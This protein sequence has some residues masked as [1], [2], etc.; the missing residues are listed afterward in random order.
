MALT[1]QST[2]VG[3][4]R[5]VITL[6]DLFVAPECRRQGIATALLAKV[7][8]LASPGA[9]LTLTYYSDNAAALSLYK[10]AKFMVAPAVILTLPLAPYQCRDLS[11][12]IN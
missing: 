8:A 12:E 1:Q 10:K 4:R 11:F 5:P 9:V 7:I 3:W 6:T 2:T